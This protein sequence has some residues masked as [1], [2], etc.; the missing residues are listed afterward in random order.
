VVVF[1]LAT[2][3]GWQS[4]VRVPGD[5]ASGN[6]ALEPVYAADLLTI[7]ELVATP[8]PLASAFGRV[9]RALFLQPAALTAFVGR[10]QKKTFRPARIS[11]AGQKDVS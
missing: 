1:Q 8:T 4:E 11:N 7:A 9:K 6:F 10:E 2:S 3:L 5:L